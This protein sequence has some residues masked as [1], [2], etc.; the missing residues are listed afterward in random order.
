METINIIKES[1][2]ANSKKY[3]KLN[4]PELSALKTSTS[5]MYEYSEDSRYKD[6]WWF[7]FIKEDIEL[8]EFIIFAGAL[9]HQNKE[10]ALFKIPTAWLTENIDNI[11][12]VAGN[13]INIYL[14]FQ[15]NVDIR[16][17]H[18]LSFANFRIN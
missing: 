9:D 2:R 11:D 1:M 4:Y 7:K 18:N 13:W 8:H 5:R 6:N 16:C 10:F 15:D 17:Q 14:T 3:I 12:I